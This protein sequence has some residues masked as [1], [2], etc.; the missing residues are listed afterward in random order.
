MQGDGRTRRRGEA[1]SFV[2][3]DYN[4]PKMF[5][6]HGFMPGILSLCSLRIREPLSAAQDYPRNIILPWLMGWV[7]SSKDSS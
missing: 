3:S 5:I 1:I 7:A 6:M 2:T 4:V